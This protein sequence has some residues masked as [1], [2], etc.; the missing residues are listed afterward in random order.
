MTKK[1]D[2]SI[3]G[4]QHEVVCLSRVKATPTPS[5]T[6]RKKARK[7][8]SVSISHQPLPHKD[9]IDSLRSVLNERNFRVEN[10]CHNLGHEGKRYFGLFQVTHSTRKGQNE[11]GTVVGLRNSNDKKFSVG[12][13]AGDAPF[14]CDNLIFSNEVEV[15]HKHTGELPQLLESFRQ[16]MVEGIGKLF[17]MWNTQDTRVDGYKNR[18]ISNSEAN[19]LIIQ[20]YKAKAINV[21]QIPDVLNQ[22]ESSDHSEFWDRNVNSLYNAFTETYKGSHVNFNQPTNVR[23]RSYALHSVLDPYAEVDVQEGLVT[24]S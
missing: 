9:V 4:N 12:M 17:T 21:T 22:W 7:D 5:A 15:K 1:L 10:E 14:V 3:C 19:D 2:L 11:R 24:L 18:E 6:Y 13:C 23:N 16:R 8:G 20:A